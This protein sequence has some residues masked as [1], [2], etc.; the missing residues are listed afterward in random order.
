VKIDEKILKEI[1]RITGGSYFRATDQESLEKIFEEID[2]LEKTKIEVKQ[3][4]R[5]S[6]MF[7]PYLFIAM[8][9]VVAE[10]TLANTK[11]RKIP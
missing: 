11:F 5:Y 10:V 7:V 2:G 1:A 4:T 3:F 8:V 6:E 9:V